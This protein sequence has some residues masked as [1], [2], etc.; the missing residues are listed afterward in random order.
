MGGVR[1]TISR[2]ALWAKRYAALQQQRASSTTV[3]TCSWSPRLSPKTHGLGASISC[4][5]SEGIEH[6]WASSSE[7]HIAG[8]RVGADTPRRGSRTATA[9]RATPPRATAT[10]TATHEGIVPDSRDA[11][12]ETESASS[13]LESEVAAP[14]R[15]ARSFADSASLTS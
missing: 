3:T 7:L 15:R 14:E 8:S 12:P 6:R 1:R 4:P 10:A 9:T 13:E 11:A 2:E 5:L